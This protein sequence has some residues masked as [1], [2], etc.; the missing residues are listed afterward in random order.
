MKKKNITIGLMGHSFQCVN[1]G[2]GALA[3]S[4]CAILKK[5][6]D[7]LGI[8]IRI[9]CFEAGESEKNYCYATEVNVKLLYYTYSPK[10]LKLFHRCD[11][12]IDATGGDS[13]SDIY[14]YKIF[15]AGIIMKT[16][17]LLSGRKVI[18]A[19]QTIGP[20]HNRLNQKIANAYMHH[21]EK[22]FIRDHISRIVLDERNRK[23]VVSTAD[24]A[25][26]LPYKKSTEGKGKGG[27]NVS[28]LLYDEENLILR[29]VGFDYVKMCESIV[30]LLLRKGW[31]VVLV[32]HVIGD[33]K[34]ITDNDYCASLK[35]REKY[36]ELEIAPLF[37][38]PV[39]AKSYISGLDFF[40][41]SR[42]HA[43][44]A[45]VSSGVPAVPIAYSRKFKGVFEQIG[46]H[47]TLEAFNLTEAE[48]VKQIEKY[49]DNLLMLKEKAISVGKNAKENLKIYEAYL[50]DAVIK[51]MG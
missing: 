45:A 1:L 25:F 14:G 24:M 2:V 20:F 42:M 28:G 36:P 43:V 5:V 10:M 46:Y 48:I 31:N 7:K 27:F 8:N 6:A 13:F 51:L 23:K 35:L 26:C 47:A 50:E 4:E 37:N 39:E 49:L 15:I 44:I 16:Y 41:G 33:E 34:T 40:I 18:L 32:P 12:I 30:E 11:M 21:V 19:P 38:N 17:A 22:I 29:Q 3:I 9:I